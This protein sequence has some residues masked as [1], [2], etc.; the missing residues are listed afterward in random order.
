MGCAAQILTTFPVL[1]AVLHEVPLLN[2]LKAN[3]LS[4]TTFTWL[5]LQHLAHARAQLPPYAT[6]PWILAMILNFVARYTI[7]RRWRFM[8]LL[9]LELWPIPTNLLLYGLIMS[10]TFLVPLLLSILQLLLFNLMYINHPSLY[11]HVTYQFCSTALFTLWYFWFIK[12]K[13]KVWCYI[14]HY[15]CCWFHALFLCLFYFS[16][17][18]STWV[19]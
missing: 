11:I 13:G 18:W 7:T 16:Y 3:C 8:P 1:R 10:L 2:T 14:V 9:F 15:N 4:N 5:V 17:I 6:L 12:C 19:L